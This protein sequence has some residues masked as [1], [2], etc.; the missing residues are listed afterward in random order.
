MA[1]SSFNGSR[2]RSIRRI[3]GLSI[4]ELAERVGVSKQAISQY[5][6]NAQAPRPDVLMSMTRQLNVAP[7][8]FRLPESSESESPVFWRSLNKA[9]K[10]ARLGATE[11]LLIVSDALAYLSRFLVLPAPVIPAVTVPDHISELTLNDIEEIATASRR[12]WMLGD[13][14]ISDLILLVENHYIPVCSANLLADE[15]DAFSALAAL[16]PVICTDIN[17]SAVRTRFNIAHELGHLVLHSRMIHSKEAL[18]AEHKLL[19]MQAHRFAASFLLPESSFLAELYT[20]TLASFLELKK[21]W[22]VSVGMMIQRSLDLGIISE[23]QYRNL[24]IAYS[25][26]GWR[27]IEPLDD[28]IPAERPRLIRR[29]FETLISNGVQSPTD[30]VM[31]LGLMPDDFQEIFD[32]PTSL[33][34]DLDELFTTHNRSNAEGGHIIHFNPSIQIDRSGK[35]NQRKD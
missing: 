19:E 28:L 8:F 26:K 9:S 16:R 32:I 12:Q 7:I 10:T 11:R 1:K 17:K 34:V 15:L 5:E 22:R 27:R 29:C 21:K 35:G 20:P 30:L 33:F 4:T 3:R 24:R 13:G 25:K 2:L 31:A 6:A 23:R 14:V 18:R